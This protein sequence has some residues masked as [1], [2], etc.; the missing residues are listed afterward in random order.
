MDSR[1]SG[2]NS[3]HFTRRRSTGF[4]VTEL[5]LSSATEKLL[6]QLLK[7]LFSSPQDFWSTTQSS[8]SLYPNLGKNA[9]KNWIDQLLAALE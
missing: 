1:G 6:C 4:L 2:K 9:T 5:S 8:D 3:A 7:H